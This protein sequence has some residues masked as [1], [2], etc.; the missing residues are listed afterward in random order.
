MS[1][2]AKELKGQGSLVMVESK[3][4]ASL[5]AT[6]LFEALTL[7]I[8]ETFAS[9]FWCETMRPV[10]ETISAEIMKRFQVIPKDQP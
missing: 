5:R 2:P 3:E 9:G 7:T 10:A 1:D 4:I 6:P 8:C